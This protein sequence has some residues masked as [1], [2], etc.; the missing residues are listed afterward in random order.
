MNYL[1]NT[2]I[3]DPAGPVLFNGCAIARKIVVQFDISLVKWH[4]GWWN[5]S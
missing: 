3:I 1:E 5:V 2:I 4:V